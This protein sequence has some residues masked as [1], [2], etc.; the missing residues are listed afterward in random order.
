MKKKEKILIARKNF[1]FVN[2]LLFLRVSIS[3]IMRRN[4]LNKIPKLMSQGQFHMTENCTGAGHAACYLKLRGTVSK[5][6]QVALHNLN[7]YNIN[8]CFTELI[9][10]RK[11][12]GNFSFMS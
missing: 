8:L 12:N 5:F 2:D 6:L 4:V 9:Q 10:L 11:D 3:L 7:F 1:G